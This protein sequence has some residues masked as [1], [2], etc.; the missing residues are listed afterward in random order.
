MSVKNR[1]KEFIKNQGLS[2]SSFEKSIGVS[3]GYVNS[4]TKGIGGGKS[5]RISR[6]YTNLN[7]D[8]LLTGEG[9]MLEKGT[10]NDYTSIEDEKNVVNESLINEKDTFLKDKIIVSLE[11]LVT[12]QKLHLESQKEIIGSKDKT[13]QILENSLAAKEAYLL[14]QIETI[15]SQKEAI[16]LLKDKIDLLRKEKT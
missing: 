1:L 9:E 14:S 13:I 16:A 10:I 8:W 15:A 3:N 6:E 11:Q 2:I 12:S 7:I 4:I 5:L